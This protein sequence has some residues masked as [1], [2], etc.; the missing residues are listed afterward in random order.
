MAENKKKPAETVVKAKPK[1][2]F[3]EP[4]VEFSKHNEPSRIEVPGWV[5]SWQN[6]D[7]K[8]KLG[9]GEHNPVKRDTELGEAVLA[10]FGVEGAQYEGLNTDTNLIFY[11]GDLVLAY[12]SADIQERRMAEKARLADAQMGI[13]SEDVRMTR[14]SV[15]SPGLQR[16]K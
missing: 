9:W 8:N 13:I 15:I 4:I 1:T 7:R 11:G 2:I 16:E 3:V 6:L 5:F 12:T 10:Q 14:H